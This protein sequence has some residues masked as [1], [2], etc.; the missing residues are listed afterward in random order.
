MIFNYNQQKVFMNSLE[1][2]DPGNTALRI[3]NI[4]GFD[5]YIILKT[6]MG[7]TSIFK[8]GPIMSGVDLFVNGFSS[9]YVKTNYKEKTIN[10]TISQFINDPYKGMISNI[11]VLDQRDVINMFPDIRGCFDNIDGE[12]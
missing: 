5:Y 6:I 4:E 11:E 8:F 12:E 9:S 7:K 3:E 2:E 1:V 10:K